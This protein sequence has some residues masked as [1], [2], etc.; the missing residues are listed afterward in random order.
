M[1]PGASFSL[2]GTSPR[3]GQSKGFE[4]VPS[5]SMASF[6]SRTASST[7]VS[8]FLEDTVPCTAPESFNCTPSFATNERSSVYTTSDTTEISPEWSPARSE[9]P[10][11]SM[12]L[13]T[14]FDNLSEEG[15]TV[16][17][18]STPKSADMMRSV[19]LSGSDARSARAIFPSPSRSHRAIKLPLMS[20]LPASASSSEASDVSS[21]SE[22]A[23]SSSSITSSSRCLTMRPSGRP[24]DG[25]ASIASSSIVI[26]GTHTV[27]PSR[28]LIP[29][30]KYA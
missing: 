17:S 30:L 29:D 21:S 22:A 9:R 28:L 16:C 5:P 13:R 19:L 18:N 20:R 8:P 12:T 2:R 1:Y 24:F 10:A 3:R 6:N 25:S 7:G 26:G 15:R 23:Q 14:S 11:H 27:S 4:A